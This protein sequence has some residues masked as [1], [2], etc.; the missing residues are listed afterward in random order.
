M[1]AG[2]LMPKNIFAN[3]PAPSN[4]GLQLYSLRN[5]VNKNLEGSLEKIA[6]IGYKNLEAAGYSEG[7]FYGLEPTEIKSMVNDLGMK[8]ISSHLTFD[9]K[10]ISTVLNAHKEAGIKYL[11]WP[12]IS[13]E[14]R[15]NLDEYKK[16]ADKLNTIGELC[17]Q[18]GLSFGYHNHDFEFHPIDG[19]IPYDFLLENTDPKHV[20][21]EIDLYWITYAGKD[22]IA[23]FEKYPGRF[24]LWHVKDMMTGDDKS[25]TEVGSGI[26]DYAKLFE[27]AS[28]SG[29]KD[30][31]VEQDVI[32]GDGFESV[33]KSFDFLSN[34]P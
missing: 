1:L 15:A 13:K 10:D 31:F 30:F 12:W 6:A 32:K 4:I 8:L 33:K 29:M 19:V 28:L 20:F 3:F 22:P 18:N 27:Y 9:P 11:V 23:Y 2:I 7:K 26:I 5:E 16:L 17:T 25:M 24:K 21:M 14:E 34:M